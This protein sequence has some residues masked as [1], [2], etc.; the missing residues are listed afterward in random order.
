MKKIL[1]LTALLAAENSSLSETVNFSETAVY[2]IEQGSSTIYSEVGEKLSMEQCLYGILVYSANET[3]NAVAEHIGGTIDDFIVMMN[4]KAAELGCT[5]SH[6]M[7]PHGLTQ[8]DHY[9]TAYDLYLIFQ[10]ALKNVRL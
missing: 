2:G 6:F 8:E 9:T 1:A 5:E 7:N 10:N 3:A 4:Q